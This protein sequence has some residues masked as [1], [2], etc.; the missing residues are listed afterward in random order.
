MHND[1][2]EQRLLNLIIYNA[3]FSYSCFFVRFFFFLI[4]L[5]LHDIFL[6]F[7][8]SGTND[9]GSVNA[10]SPPSERYTVTNLVPNAFYKFYFDGISSCG[11]N[12]SQM[13][14]AETRRLETSA[15]G[16]L[17]TVSYFHNFFFSF[18]FFFFVGANKKIIATPLT[19]AGN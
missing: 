19:S 12:L 13:I 1:P 15:S 9:D 18:F 10:G 17:G 14:E 8:Y 16:K 7:T 6:K 2:E 11:R 4:Y 3:L 5:F